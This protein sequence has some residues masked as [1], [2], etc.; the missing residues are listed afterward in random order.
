MVRR[1]PLLELVLQGSVQRYDKMVHEG[2]SWLELEFHMRWIGWEFMNVD[3]CRVW[4]REGGS[5][6]RTIMWESAEP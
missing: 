4:R 2:N 6:L 1:G 5:L 3:V